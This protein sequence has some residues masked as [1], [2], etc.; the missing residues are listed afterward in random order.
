MLVAT[1]AN[2][3]AH[4]HSFEAWGIRAADVRISVARQVFSG[5]TGQRAPTR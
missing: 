2:V 5:I 3:A 4:Q 1:L